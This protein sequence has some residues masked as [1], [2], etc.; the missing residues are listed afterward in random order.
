MAEIGIV[1]YGY[2]GKA[3]AASIKTRYSNNITIFDKSE[4]I[5][6]PFED[7]TIDN[8]INRLDVLFVCLPTPTENGIQNSSYLYNFFH[9]LEQVKYKGIVVIKS[10]VLYSSI[11][12]YITKF[13]IVVNPEFLNAQTS[14]FDFHEQ[15]HIVL[16]GDPII[17]NQIKSL[18]NEY[19]DLPNITKT[20]SS[21]YNFTLCTIQEAI[22]FKYIR[23][24]K[25]SLNVLYWNMVEDIT[26]D[27]EKMSDMMRYFPTDEL[28]NIFHNGYRGYGG[29]CLQKDAQALL[30]DTH[31]KFIENMEEYNERLHH[32]REAY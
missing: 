19:F 6:R 28:S 12:Q 8:T 22:H 26:D 27:A 18:Y 32:C 4:R 21:F 10:T 13:K 7:T 3:V 5:N 17:V 14:I 1:G 25:N 20:E 11:K 24:L 15:K 2:V 9:K 30:N 23:N 16:G 31:H 29:A